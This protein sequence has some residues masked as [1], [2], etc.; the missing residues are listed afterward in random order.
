MPDAAWINLMAKVITTPTGQLVSIYH[1]FTQTQL[2]AG[3]W[4]NRRYPCKLSMPA[5]KRMPADGSFLARQA[6][7]HLPQT[8][9]EGCRAELVDALDKDPLAYCL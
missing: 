2:R 1:L 3:P 5:R 6:I 9:N 8:R 7:Y 4:R